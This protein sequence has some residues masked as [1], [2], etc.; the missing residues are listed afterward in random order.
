M[1]CSNVGNVHSLFLEADQAQG[2]TDYGL[3]HRTQWL[4]ERWDAG[5]K[6]RD[7]QVLN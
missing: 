3:L 4:C 6:A 5:R 2:V 1:G 7:S